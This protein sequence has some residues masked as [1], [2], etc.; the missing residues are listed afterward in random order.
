MKI[1]TSILMVLGAIGII[2]LI[3]FALGCLLYSLTPSI[4]GHMTETQVTNEAA[5][6]FDAKINTLKKQIRTAVDNKEKKEFT[7]TVTEE[8]V[9]SK[10]I[11]LIA[12]GQLPMKEAM[13]NFVEDS[14]WLYIQFN[15]PGINTKVGI[16]AKLEIVKSDIKIIVQD[17]HIGR[18]PLPNSIRDWVSTFFD[19]FIKLQDPAKDLSIDITNIQINDKKFTARGITKISG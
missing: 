12:E 5:E 14:C 16:I 9:N 8:E 17:F 10:I 7:L 19:A 15:N 2:F 3:V 6:R 18:L 4:K 11:A 13:I 1:F